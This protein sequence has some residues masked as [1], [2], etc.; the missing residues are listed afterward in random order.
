MNN[1]QRPNPDLLLTAIQQDE[2]RR[3]RGQ[4]KIFLGMC[5]GVGKTYAMLRAA[6]QRQVD[7]VDV[8][9]A[10]AETHGRLETEF[11]LGGLTQISRREVKYRDVT[12][13]E[14]DLD[15]VLQRKPQ[16]A[17]VDELAHTNTPGSRHPKRYQDVLEILDAGIDVYTT[18]NIQHI[19]SRVDVIRQITGIN[20]HETVPDLILDQT[21]EIQLVDLP[22]DQLQ[23]RLAE[24]KVYLGEQAKTAASNFFR[25]ENLAALREIALRVTAEHVGHEL[26][27]TLVSKRI[28]GTWKAGETLMCAVGPSPFSEGLIRWT[29]R[30]AAAMD[31]DWVAVY[32]EV[33]PLDEDNTARLTKHLSLARQLGA[34]IVTT[35]GADVAEALLRVAHERHVTQIVIGKSPV[36]PWRRFLRGASLVDRLIR[37]SGDIDICIVQAEKRAEHSSKFTSPVQI[38]SLFQEAFLGIVSVLGVTVLCWFIR[39]FTGYWAVALIYLSLVVYLATIFNRRTILI[40]AAASALLWDYFF[41]PPPFSLHVTRLHDALMLIMYFVV[42]LVI[43]QLTARLR[44]NELAERKREKRTAAL[45]R[46]AQCA[47]ESTT[48]DEGLERAI[49]EIQSI[50]NAQAAIVLANENG[51]LDAASHSAGHRIMDEKEH[52]VAV[53]TFLNSRPSGRFTDT[54]P[55]AQGLYLPLQSAK[56]RAGVLAVYFMQRRSLTIDERELLETFADQIAAMI[57]RYWLIR[58][59][60]RIQLAEESERFYKTL[61][62]CVSHELKTPLAVITAAAGELRKTRPAD[63]RV[64][65][66]IDAAV[67]RQNRI[68]ENLLDMTRIE[69]G[70]LK[71]DH[72][73]SDIDELIDTARQ[74]VADLLANHRFKV[75]IPEDPPSVNVDAG[76]MEHALAN[77]L[78]NAALYSPPG[79]EIRV[80]AYVDDKNLVIQVADEGPGI[81]P[82]V[83]AR[84]FDKFYRGPNARPGGTGLGLSIV[85]GLMQALGGVVRAE[86]GPAG[87]AVFTVQIPVMTKKISDNV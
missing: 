6:Q 58:K 28:Y 70:R 32:V 38:G 40:V 50:F 54:L 47:V 3:G 17:I 86:N 7:G 53:W 36:N 23:K 63:G 83:A 66:E 69:S 18:L 16:L 79:S 15:A 56:T 31:A 80:S 76:I 2:K 67:S 5:A 8:V 13:W 11:L 43:G 59:S 4:L 64:L 74:S 24:G 35:T 1:E 29:R 42:A 52:S 21:D 45:Y 27:D 46:M 30:I 81:K 10:I 55:E 19:E 73:W 33:E 77:L 12:L 57:E 20:V 37:Q 51:T 65:N 72:V 49:R 68:I 82:E 22:P 60:G 39:N 78:A 61:F 62:A 85:R 87:G 14:M 9:V 26:H 44:L 41:I 25:E 75:F 48:L 34:E 84:M 71:L